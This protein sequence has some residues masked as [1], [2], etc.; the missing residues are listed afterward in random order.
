MVDDIIV[1][2]LLEEGHVPFADLAPENVSTADADD[3]PPGGVAV[4]IAGLTKSF[5]AR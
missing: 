4:T 1:R 2:A 3:T 5:G